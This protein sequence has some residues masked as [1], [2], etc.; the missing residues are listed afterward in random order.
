[1]TG[2]NETE[3]TFGRYDRTRSRTGELCSSTGREKWQTPG[4]M[5]RSFSGDE[6]PLDAKLQGIDELGDLG[7]ELSVP[8]NDASEVSI[9]LKQRSAS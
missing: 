8:L 9:L 6:I 1:M 7:A 5:S 4:E 2:E 3:V